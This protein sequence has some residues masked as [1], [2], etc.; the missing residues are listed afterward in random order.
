MIKKYSLLVLLNF[1]LVACEIKNL[2]QSLLT[3]TFPICPAIGLRP[4]GTLSFSDEF[5]NKIKIDFSN[6]GL[7]TSIVNQDRY[8]LKLEDENLFDVTN[9]DFSRP[10]STSDNR[11]FYQDQ[12]Y[13]E[14]IRDSSTKAGDIEFTILRYENNQRTE[15]PFFTLKGVSWSYEEFPP[16]PVTSSE[17]NDCDSIRQLTHEI[18]LL[19]YS[20]LVEY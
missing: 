12:K 3:S 20:E 9:I 1:L 18:K 17:Q 10:P 19:D 5:R 11:L 14:I 6:K 7:S 8:M 4:P 16:P 15:I 13:F 2:E